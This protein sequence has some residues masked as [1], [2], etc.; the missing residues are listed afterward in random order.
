MNFETQNFREFKQRLNRNSRA[1]A[2]DATDFSLVKLSEPLANALGR[3]KLFNFLDVLNVSATHNDRT[4][5]IRD[6][7]RDFVQ[8]V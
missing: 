2:L 3:E 1:A 6:N 5:N 4:I 7:R 8:E